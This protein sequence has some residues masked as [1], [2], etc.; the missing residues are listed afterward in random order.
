LHDGSNAP[1]LRYGVTLNAKVAGPKFG[2]RLR[3]IQAALEA[4]N[5]DAIVQSMLPIGSKPIEVPCP[6]GSVMLEHADLKPYIV[7]PD[8]WAG[9]ADG[10]TQVLIDTR[11][12]SELKREGQAREIIRNVQE[13][14]KSAGLEMED[15]IVLALTT[16]SA[17]LRQAIDAHRDYIAAECLVREWATQLNGVATAEAKIEGQALSIALRKA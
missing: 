16:E 12:S 3:E 5:Q 7:A 15:R 8:G 13:L 17:E 1:L 6:G 11:I 9:I 2:P 4:A 14:R 10:R